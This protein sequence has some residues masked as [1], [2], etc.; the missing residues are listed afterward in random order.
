MRAQDDSERNRR[1]LVNRRAGRAHCRR[2]Q[3][4]CFH[5]CRA[6]FFKKFVSSKTVDRTLRYSPSDPRELLTSRKVAS[7]SELPTQSLAICTSSV[8][9]FAVRRNCFG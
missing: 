2:M 9:F 6:I 3:D 4:G 8:G 5:F 1:S 7:S